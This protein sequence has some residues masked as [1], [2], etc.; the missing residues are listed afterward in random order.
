MSIH[1]SS[2]FLCARFFNKCILVFILTGHILQMDGLSNLAHIFVERLCGWVELRVRVARFVLSIT[3]HR[4][5]VTVC[6]VS[7]G[8]AS[9]LHSRHFVCQV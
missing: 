7:T 9:N 3:T 5:L 1:R 6:V 2:G 8:A 4:L